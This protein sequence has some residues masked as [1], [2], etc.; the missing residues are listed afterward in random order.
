MTQ[1]KKF[2]AGGD[3]LRRFIPEIA[4]LEGKAVHEPWTAELDG[5]PQPLVEL[6][7]SRERA[8]DAYQ[9]LKDS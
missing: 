3:Y 4:G 2:D 7:E 8:L 6:P 9:K 1:S 5:Y